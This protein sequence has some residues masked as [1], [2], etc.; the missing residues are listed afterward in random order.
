VSSSTDNIGYVIPRRIVEHFLHEYTTHGCFRC[1]LRE[2]VG[3]VGCGGGEVGSHR[4]R[5]A[6]EQHLVFG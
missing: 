2:G 5:K 4:G 3:D 1:A 6:G